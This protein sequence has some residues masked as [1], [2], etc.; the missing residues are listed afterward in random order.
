[1]GKRR[2]QFKGKGKIMWG[3]GAFVSVPFLSAVG[4]SI[5]LDAEFDSSILM[6]VI[7]AEGWLS[8]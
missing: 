8:G 4:V 6:A 1:M 5:R 3:N 7:R 2:H